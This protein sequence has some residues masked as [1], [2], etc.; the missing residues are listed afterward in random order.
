MV[1]FSGCGILWE[2]D[3]SKKKVDMFSPPNTYTTFTQSQTFVWDSIPG[4]SVYQFQIVSKR[5]DYIEDYV[6]DTT[7]S[8]TSIT[9]GLIPREYQWRVMGVNN[10]GE[11]GFYVY[12]LT[13]NEDT[14][15]AN[16]I[17][18]AI[19]PTSNTTYTTDSVAF[20]WTLISL[21]EQYE[22]QVASHPSFNSQ[23]IKRDSTTTNDYIYLEDM[24][25]LGTFYWRIR[26]MRVGVDTTPY[27]TTAQFTIDMA[28]IQQTPTNNVT[29]L[30]PF[31]MSWLRASNVAKDSLFLYYNNTTTPYKKIEL[32]ANNY[33]FSNVD[34]IG[35]GSG[36][37]YWEVKSL[38]DNNVQSS[39]SNLR[40]FTIN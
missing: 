25:G 26:A 2:E 1:L 18:S 34:T 12:D 11:S 38:G 24:L 8:G 32:T 15:L 20:W 10:A 30:L 35:Y 36:V 14:T 21:A 37:Y 40:Q 33:T 7:F 31:N 16:Q 5:F 23:T 4:A 29:Q 22:L 3:L 17:V 13:I 19:V 9:L 39:W 27:S 28:P 6:L